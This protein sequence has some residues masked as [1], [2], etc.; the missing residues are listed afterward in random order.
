MNREHEGPQVARTGPTCVSAETVA[1]G[2]AW[3][4]FLEVTL[5]ADP[6]ATGVDPH[7]FS[8]L[9]PSVFSL[10]ALMSLWRSTSVPCSAQTSAHQGLH[11]QSQRRARSVHVAWKGCETCGCQRALSMQIRAPQPCSPPASFT[12]ACAFTTHAPPKI[13]SGSC[14]P[15]QPLAPLPLSRISSH[16][17]PF[18]RAHAQLGPSAVPLRLLVPLPEMFTSL[19]PEPTSRGSL[20]KLDLLKRPILT[21]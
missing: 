17:I 2:R 20:P 11:P 7:Y 4:R 8:H 1:G 18:S 10:V 13:P 12:C 9:S 15:L 14:P 16:P 5:R 6:R 21:L 19:F 3:R